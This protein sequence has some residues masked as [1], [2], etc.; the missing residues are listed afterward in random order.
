MKNID[1]VFKYLNYTVESDRYDET[2][3]FFSDDRN[4]IRE[5]FENLS[6]Y[7]AKEQ[8][9]KAIDFLARNLKP[10][11]YI[12]LIL[13]DTY[14]TYLINNKSRYVKHAT[15][16]SKWENAAKT[17][18]KIG[19]PKIHVIVIPMFYW[20]LDPNWPG[21][22]II[23]NLLFSLPEDIIT[24]ACSTILASPGKY[25]RTDYA[26]LKDTI[27]EFLKDFKEQNKGNKGTF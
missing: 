7:A 26:D 13:A 18:A 5:Q 22:M 16:K 25:K 3:K 8:Q 1:E 15:D 19:W 4:L 23:K 11:E 9:N 17:I 27:D 24:E 10:C 2:L 12:Y 14:S 20:I 21:S 6:W